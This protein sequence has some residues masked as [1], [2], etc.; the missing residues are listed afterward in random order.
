MNI[1]KE[2]VAPVG[3]ILDPSSVVPGEEAYSEAVQIVVTTVDRWQQEAWFYPVL[4]VLL[5]WALTWK[6]LAL[7]H[8]ARNRQTAWFVVLFLGNT[9]GIL[10]ILYLRFFQ[11]KHKE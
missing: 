6:A 4:V 1:V 11:K 10:E 7:W 9:V 8:A 3:N 5:V 2:G